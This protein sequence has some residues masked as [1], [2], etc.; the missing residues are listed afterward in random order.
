MTATTLLLTCGLLVAQAE[1]PENG[2]C[3]EQSSP[4]P[5]LIDWIH[6]NDF[7]MVGLRPN[8]YDYHALCGFRHGFDFLVSRGIDR[9]YASQGRLTLNRLA[10]HRLLFINL[11]SAEREPF[12]VSEV[13]AIRD[14]VKD[15]GSLLIVMD[16]SNCYFHSHR[17]KP[18]LAVFGIEAFTDTACDVAPHAIGK[19]NAWLA[20]TTFSPHPITKGLQRLGYQTGGRLDPRYS[21]A[22]TSAQAWADQW[23]VGLYGQ[24]DDIGLYGNF[25]REPQEAPGPLGVV[26]AR[27]FHNGRIVVVGD[28][29]MWGD[30][31]MNYADN[32]RLWLNTMAWLLHD[33]KLTDW[34]AYETWHAPRVVLYEP[35]DRPRFGSCDD[36]DYYHLLCL[37]TRHFWTFTNDRLDEPADLRI[38]VDSAREFSS[39]EIA[40]LTGYLRN[41]GKLLILPHTPVGPNADEGAVQPLAAS[42]DLSDTE[43]TSTEHLTEYAFSGGGRLAVLGDEPV[44]DSEH[45]APPTRMPNAEEGARAEAILEIVRRLLAE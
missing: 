43:K 40:K 8:V 45:L 1:P 28:Q 13:M 25:E 44:L 42:L 38:V 18:L 22:W 7:S 41:R 14:Y 11:P 37:L 17:L 23:R 35:A 36:Y 26:A 10:A 20:I 29:N 5:I 19:G 24:T 21:V 4:A 6:A 15:G 31:F 3:A 32:Y 12:L 27:E 9:E 30:A 39:D 33:S 16:H 34:K 2:D